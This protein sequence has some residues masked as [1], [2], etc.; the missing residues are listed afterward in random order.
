MWDRLSAK[1]VHWHVLRIHFLVYIL[2]PNA[3]FGLCIF[4]FLFNFVSISA[5]NVSYSFCHFPKNMS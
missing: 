4:I 2:F 1:A 5:K 3:Q